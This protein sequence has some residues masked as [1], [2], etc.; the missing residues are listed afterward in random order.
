MSMMSKKTFYLFIYFLFKMP[1]L[2]FIVYVSDHAFL[3][4]SYFWD[5]YARLIRSHDT[6]DFVADNYFTRN[7]FKTNTKIII[8]ILNYYCRC[9]LLIVYRI[10]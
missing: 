8:I 5:K 2:Q 10:K 4:H 3:G 9:G 1:H 6:F 7:V